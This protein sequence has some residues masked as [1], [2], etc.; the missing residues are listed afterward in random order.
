MQ[1]AF[2]SRGPWGGRRKGWVQG[3]DGV[4]WG[5]CEQGGSAGQT[6]GCTPLS[7]AFLLCSAPPG[8]P[9]LRGGTRAAAECRSGPW[10]LFPRTA[11]TVYKRPTCSVS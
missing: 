3:E 4:K 11:L 6:A 9:L 1:N 7:S 2:L 10:E 8:L 5:E